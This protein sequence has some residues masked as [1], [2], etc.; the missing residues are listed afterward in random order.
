MNSVIEL[1]LWL[2]TELL[3]TY[4]TLNFH[5]WNQPIIVA[6]LLKGSSQEPSTPKSDQTSVPMP[7]MSRYEKFPVIFIPSAVKCW[8]FTL[9]SVYPISFTL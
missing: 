5:K 3:K 8:Q 2:A 9:N 1:P 7:Q 6:H 4:E